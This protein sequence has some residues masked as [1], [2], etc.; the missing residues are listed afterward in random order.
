MKTKYLQQER[1]L[2]IEEG[3]LSEFDNLDTL[4]YEYDLNK[5]VWNNIQKFQQSIKDWQEKSVL[6][7]SLKEFQ[8]NMEEWNKLVQ[9]ALVD[10]DLS[11]VP[12]E[13]YKKIKQY[14]LYYPILEAMQNKLILNDNLLR[15]NLRILI[16]NIPL[17]I[18]SLFMLFFVIL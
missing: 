12:R 11:K 3:N 7:I 4:L 15:D 9:V 6:E 17:S 14:E 2:E 1:D 5:N 8:S 16:S 18:F 13:F 10:L